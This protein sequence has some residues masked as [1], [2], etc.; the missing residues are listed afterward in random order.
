MLL[1][2]RPPT[3]SLPHR[4]L[5]D[6]PLQ[7]DHVPG[8]APA[9]AAD[10]TQRVHRFVDPAPCVELALVVVMLPSGARHP[11]DWDCSQ[12]VELRYNE[13]GL[14]IA[15][16]IVHLWRDRPGLEHPAQGVNDAVMQHRSAVGVGL[17][18]LLELATANLVGLHASARHGWTS[19]QPYDPAQHNAAK[20]FLSLATNTG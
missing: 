17:A 14:E 15:G 18:D 3:P 12:R 4:P 13:R 5:P 7:A 10:P 9:G 16:C 11:Q 20:S 2:H 1:A 6:A 19:R 8:A